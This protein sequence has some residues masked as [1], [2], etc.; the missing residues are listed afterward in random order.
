[1]P[2]YQSLGSK[3][4]GDCE[5]C[6]VLYSLLLTSRTME[7]FSLFQSLDVSY[8][9]LWLVL[10]G[11]QFCLPSGFLCFRRYHFILMSYALPPPL[12]FSK[13]YF[14]CYL[15]LVEDLDCCRE[16][17]F[18]YPDP[19]L[20]FISLWL[21]F[22]EDLQWFITVF[23]LWMYRKT[24]FMHNTTWCGISLSVLDFSVLLPCI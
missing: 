17:S 19:L 21:R 10:L 24:V 16:M 13:D 5:D 7:D 1:M 23:L 3:H 9:V 22:I 18:N 8:L 14:S 11:L 2:L 6:F 12:P 20:A 4:R 15:V